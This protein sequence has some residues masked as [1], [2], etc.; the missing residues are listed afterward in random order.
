MEEIIKFVDVFCDSYNRNV[1]APEE[2][3]VLPSKDILIKICSTLLNASCIR[4]ELRFASYRVCFLSGDSDYLDAFVYA[5][6]LT[7]EK[8]IPFSV[9]GLHKLAPALNPN[10]CYLCLDTSSDPFLITGMIAS[11][12]SW[13]KMAIGEISDGNRM[14]M[15]PNIYVKSPGEID[16]CFGE[17]SLVS[18]CFGRTVISRPDVFVKGYVAEELKSGSSVPHEELCQFMSRVLWN[19]DSYQHGGTILIVPSEEACSKYVGIKFKL[20][21]RYLFQEEKSLIDISETAREKELSSYADFIAKLTTVD[22]AVLLTKNL[23]LIGFGVEILT[24]KM[25][26]REPS[27]RFLKND[28]EPDKTKRFNDNGTRHRSGYRFAHEVEHSVVIICSQDGVMKACTKIGG[29]VVVYNN[30]TFSLI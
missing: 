17:K 12:T 16:G 10:M 19:V 24:D 20:P 5:H 18:Y 23:D 13:E 11:Y 22:G 2:E 25:G 21:C 29:D 14:P 9:D 27:M 7:L 15:I 4:D 1:Q 8:P 6:K 30:I 26:K 3:Q 28:D